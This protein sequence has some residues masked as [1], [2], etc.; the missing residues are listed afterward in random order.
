[1]GFM[2]QEVALEGKR[3]AVQ[4]Y[5]SNLAYTRR[6]ESIADGK[7]ENEDSGFPTHGPKRGH[8]SFFYSRCV[9]TCNE[10][11]AGHDDDDNTGK[12]EPS[13]QGNILSFKNLSVK[14][15]INCK[16]NVGL[17]DVDLS[18]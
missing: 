18:P 2:S 4:F 16:T 6:Q 14:Q 11:N 9:H 7:K 8:L 17:A 3:K 13:C 15:C 10:E 5:R 12:H 1:M